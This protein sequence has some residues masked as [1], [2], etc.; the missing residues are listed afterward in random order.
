MSKEFHDIFGSS[1]VEQF[2][3]DFSAKI[4]WSTTGGLGHYPSIG[5]NK[6]IEDL[7][8]TTKLTYDG[9]KFAINFDNLSREFRDIIPVRPLY[10]LEEKKSQD[11]IE[12]LLNIN[13]GKKSTEAELKCKNYLMKATEEMGELGNLSFL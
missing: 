13:S 9:D 12:A 8:I 4:D 1:F 5:L 6:L 2:D 7:G 3:R 10:L 11:I